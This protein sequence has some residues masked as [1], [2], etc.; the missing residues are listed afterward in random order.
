MYYSIIY[1]LEITLRKLNIFL[2]PYKFSASNE[3]NSYWLLCDGRAL[4]KEDYKQLFK[5]IGT[6][7]NIDGTDED[8]F[9][10]PDFRGLRLLFETI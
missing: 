9:N 3:N 4:K 10:L 7:F 8:S 2:I 1:A 5:V 6:D